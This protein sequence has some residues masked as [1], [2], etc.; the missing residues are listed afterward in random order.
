MQHPSAYG[1]DWLSTE[2]IAA[3]D[4]TLLTVWYHLPKEKSAPVFVVFHGNTGHF[5]DVG[6]PDAKEKLPYD[7]QYRLKLLE[8][9]HEAAA[10]VIA[11]S[12]RG[13]GTSQG[14]PSEA[15]FKADVEAAALY[16]ME[17][18]SI[19]PERL[20][21]LGESLGAAVA[22]MM[23]EHLTEL[24]HP[25]ALLVKIAPFAS[26]AHRA[27]EDYPEFTLEQIQAALRHSFDSLK[28]LGKLSRD[29]HL[30]LLHPVEDDV[31]PPHH[32]H[33]LKEAAQTAG[34]HVSHEEISGGHIT[35]DPKEVVSKALVTYRNL[36][37]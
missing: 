10:G 12:L 19:K 29:T 13:Y 34:L 33:K 17:H 15:G 5:G 35:W 11:V 24:G 14:Q 2:N 8:A 25:P 22:G 7:R 26:I 23:A 4:G 27:V 37:A 6:R 31:T 21:L 1:F 18:L 28:R 3:K 30:Y 9:I 32:S 20:I 36:Q 16:A